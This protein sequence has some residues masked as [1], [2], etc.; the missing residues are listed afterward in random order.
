MI[1]TV[2]IKK[3]HVVVTAL[4]LFSM[5]AINAYASSVQKTKNTIDVLSQ[6]VYELRED[7]KALKKSNIEEMSTMKNDDYA[8]RSSIM[9]RFLFENLKGKKGVEGNNDIFISNAKYNYIPKKYGTLQKFINSTGVVADYSYSLFPVEE[10]HKIMIL[11]FRILNCDRN[12]ENILLQIKSRKEDKKTL[13]KL[14][15]IDHALSFPSSLE[16]GD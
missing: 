7:N 16:I 4:A 9:Q 14:I 8:K 3:V 12:D 11:D 15:P 2:N 5:I 10:A 6:E 13:Y 1:L